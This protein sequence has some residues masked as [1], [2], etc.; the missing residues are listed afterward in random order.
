[1]LRVNVGR[2]NAVVAIAHSL[3]VLLCSCGFFAVQFLLDDRIRTS[4][5]IERIS[6]L[7][8]LGMMPVQSA[9]RARQEKKEIRRQ[10]QTDARNERRA[11]MER[12][13]RV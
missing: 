10:L 11:E 13:K 8:T 1:M 6:G 3:V 4:E 7:T 2:Q 5:D 9:E 12:S